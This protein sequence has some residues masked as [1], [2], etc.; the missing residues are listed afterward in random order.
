MREGIGEMG[1]LISMTSFKLNIC[2]FRECHAISEIVLSDEYLLLERELN[3][4][5]KT[6]NLTNKARKSCAWCTGNLTLQIP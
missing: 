2:K 1:D 6:E 4:P 3:D 5:G